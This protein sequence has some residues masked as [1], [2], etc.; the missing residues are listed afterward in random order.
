MRTHLLATAILLLNRG[1]V[2]QALPRR[3]VGVST[4]L[5]AVFSDSASR[6]QE[7]P[8]WT[9][10]IDGGLQGTPRVGLEAG[11]EFGAGFDYPLFSCELSSGPCPQ[12][13]HLFSLTT[14]L[15]LNLGPRDH[16]TRHRLLIG[17]GIY[18]LTST[19][20]STGLTPGKALG[21]NLGLQQRLLRWLH[22]DL[23]AIGQT[24]WIPRIK[25]AGLW[26][27]DFGLGARV[28]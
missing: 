8:R 4:G 1:A 24:I 26:F 17:P 13:F 23:A 22:G 19:E 15:A 10:R 21:V 20:P 28:F 12:A 6:Y 7:S 16:L 25:G 2:A 11:F 27:I 3:W 5:G 18:R 9:A 14:D